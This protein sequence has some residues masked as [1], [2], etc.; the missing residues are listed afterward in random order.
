MKCQL[1]PQGPEG[2]IKRG[3]KDSGHQ[4]PVFYQQRAHYYYASFLQTLDI[5]TGFQLEALIIVEYAG[6]LFLKINQTHNEPLVNKK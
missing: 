3:H 4:S 6:I 1:F 2:Q 5:E